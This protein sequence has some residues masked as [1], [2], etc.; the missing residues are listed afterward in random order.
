MAL[1]AQRVAGVLYQAGWH[2]RIFGI[3]VSAVIT[4]GRDFLFFHQKNTTKKRKEVL[5]HGR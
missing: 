5:Y 1:F 4:V 2:R 3:P